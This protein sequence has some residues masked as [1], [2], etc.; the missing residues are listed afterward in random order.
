MATAGLR[1]RKKEQTRDTMFR[2]A[3][4]LFADRGFEHV[5][6]EEIAAACDVSPRTFFRYF[7][8]KED[9]LFADGDALRSRVIGLLDAQ[10]QRLSV[11]QVLEAAM[12][13]VAS[14]YAGQRDV[15]ELRRKIVEA[16]PSLQTR[17][18]ESKQG[19]EAEIVAHLRESGRARRTSDLELRLVVAVC[20][21]ALRT[22]IETWVASA[23]A[24]DLVKL[25]RAA[26][27]RLRSG[28]E[29]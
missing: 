14:H 21:T 4:H 20:T 17:S 7:S 27:R 1:E 16:T 19:W 9:V 11:F 15:L 5:T 10:D 28:F 25:T 2:T 23:G 13:E 8:V 24:D 22:A 3:L 12:L 26:F 18:A 29:R 6:V